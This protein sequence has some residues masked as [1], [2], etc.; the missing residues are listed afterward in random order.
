MLRSFV[1]IAAFAKIERVTQHKPFFRA[2][3]DPTLR[4]LYQ[5]AFVT[6]VTT[7]KTPQYP[8]YQANIR[9]GFLQRSG[10]DYYIEECEY[11][12]IDQDP[13]NRLGLAAIP[14][15]NGRSFQSGHIDWNWQHRTIYVVA[16]PE[17]DHLFPAI[18]V[19]K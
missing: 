2:L 10:D 6:Q 12:R 1:E 8:C 3:A 15:V 19:G 7:S 17:D 11:G 9:T 18:L 16:D 13:R 5:R 14:D 4:D